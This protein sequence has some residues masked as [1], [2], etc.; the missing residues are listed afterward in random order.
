MNELRFWTGYGPL[1]FDGETWIGA[2]LGDGRAIVEIS[3]APVDRADDT[4]S[5]GL[6]VQVALTEQS[7]R[8]PWLQDPRRVECTVG[9]IYRTESTAWTKLNYVY[10]G[11]L[12]SPRI[13]NGVL[14][15][16]VVPRIDLVDEGDPLKWDRT[17]GL[18]FEYVPR[19]STGELE[20][21][22]PP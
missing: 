15:L 20:I 10:H 1:V 4:T 12:S 21:R 9:W 2:S 3:N 19:L 18:A 6:Q 7:A 5:N 8:D 22:W 11:Y 13:A 16:S 14:T 17:R